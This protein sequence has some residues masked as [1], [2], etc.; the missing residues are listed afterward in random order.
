MMTKPDVV[1][2]RRLY[3]AFS[4][5]DLKNNG[6]LNLREFTSAIEELGLKSDEHN[7][8]RVYFHQADSDDD[9]TIDVDEFC[10]F[11]GFISESE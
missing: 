3:A 11:I 4:A 10:D 7:A 5:A 8:I 2:K 9:G 6:T 1:E